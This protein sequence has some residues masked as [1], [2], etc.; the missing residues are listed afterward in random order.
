[1]RLSR[2][3]HYALRM[4]RP[5]SADLIVWRRRALLAVMLLTL[6]L[7]TT[8]V[9]S[10]WRAE[11]L[12]RSTAERVLQEYAAV[13]AWRF[14]SAAGD[15][16][17]ASMSRAFSPAFGLSSHATPVEWPSVAVLR[18]VVDTTGRC[19][20]DPR[21][22]DRY[23]FRLD[24]KRGIVTS[25]GATLPPQLTANLVNAVTVRAMSRAPGRVDWDK[26]PN[27]R[28]GRGGLRSIAFVVRHDARD[29][30]MVAYGFEV[31]Q[32]VART[33][34]YEKIMATTPLL[35]EALTGKLPNDSML[36]V[37]VTGTGTLDAEYKSAARYL[38]RFS[39]ISTVQSARDTLRHEVRLNP[40]LASRL[41]I[42]GIP[43]SRLPLY[44]GFLVTVLGA[45]VAAILLVRQE[46]EVARARTEFVAGVSHELRTPLSQIL[47]ATETMYLGRVRSEDGRREMT[48]MVLQEAR[49][50]MHL[51]DN[52]LTFAR[53]E[54]RLNL[55]SREPVQVAAF[56]EDVVA[57][58]APLAEEAGTRFR[59]ACAVDLVVS[60][61]REALRQILLNL[62]DNAAK[63]GPPGQLVTVAADR[64]AEGVRLWV[65]DEG[66]GVTQSDRLRIWLP[67]VRVDRERHQAVGG[68]GLGLSVVRE[69]VELHGGRAWVE[70]SEA[71]SVA[72][73]N[74]HAHSTRF[75][76]DIP[77]DLRRAPH[78]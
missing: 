29:T 22:D 2:T 5:T 13:A 14:S 72:A 16:L 35:P 3:P 9:H 19:D 18:E 65:S 36:A 23:F 15:A 7:T 59:V 1:M 70:R 26:V 69:L 31:C 45:T 8:L 78:R 77:D 48:E 39:A 43:E 28:S 4:H 74:A 10:A 38:P 52:V 12:H 68:S 30:P 32:R 63:Y 53:S 67:Y 58:F 57:G 51:V 34:V 24:L 60:V 41:I 6:T 44:I 40:A 47:M 64:T 54:R 33:R 76:V 37:S 62:L 55:L 49:R 21:A 66:T 75:V 20:D 27:I 17:D 25:E 56:L 71:R 50:M 11:R 73:E 46:E 61:D 42:G